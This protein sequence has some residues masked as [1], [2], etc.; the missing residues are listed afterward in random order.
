MLS[1]E[2]SKFSVDGSVK[3]A[4]APPE[5]QR[6]HRGDVG[7]G[8]QGQ[9]GD[10]AD[11]VAGRHFVGRLVRQGVDRGQ[12]GADQ[13][14]GGPGHGSAVYRRLKEAPFSPRFFIMVM[15]VV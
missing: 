15:I 3:V 10:V 1:W 11:S 8:Q 7:Q 6:H 9:P 5:E 4:T 12:F 13:A 14:Q 2:C